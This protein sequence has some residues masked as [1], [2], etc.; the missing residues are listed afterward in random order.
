MMGRSFLLAVTF[1]SVCCALFRGVKLPE[2]EADESPP[3][4][5]EDKGFHSVQIQ[6]KYS[7]SNFLHF[8]L[9]Y[10]AF[11]S[12]RLCGVLF[13]QRGKLACFNKLKHF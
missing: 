12:V 2:H 13:R 1:I 7:T 5:A 9:L 6:C 11:R 8:C 4:N 10:S 3:Y